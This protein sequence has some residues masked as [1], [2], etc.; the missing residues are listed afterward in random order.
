MLHF[1]VVTIPV[2]ESI[3]VG[4]VERVFID[5]GPLIDATDGDSNVTWYY[6]G[7]KLTNGTVPNVVVSQDKKQSIILV[8]SLAVDEHPGNSGNYTCEVC[9][10]INTCTTHTSTAD[11]CGE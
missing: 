10:D 6:N 11:V 3:K 8:S 4:V 1:S 9:S 7:R 2:G 5:C